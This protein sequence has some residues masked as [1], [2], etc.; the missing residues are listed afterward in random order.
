MHS[1]DADKTVNSVAW[2]PHEFGLLLA[3]GSSDGKVSIVQWC[4]DGSW[5]TD[6]EFVAHQIGCN[7][8]SWAPSAVPG[9][10]VSVTGGAVQTARKRLVT[11][12]C[13]NLVKI[14]RYTGE[15]A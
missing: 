12:G 5:K 2:A 10:L 4:E 8:V 1:A 13:D 15:P 7:A 11:G 3:C 14:W 6:G 9:T